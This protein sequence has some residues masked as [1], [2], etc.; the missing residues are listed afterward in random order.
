M[1]YSSSSCGSVFGNVRKIRLA[2]QI[3]N[4]KK[5]NKKITQIL[6]LPV[7]KQV[8]NITKRFQTQ[9][10][11]CR[12]LELH[13]IPGFVSINEKFPKLRKS[14]DP[15][16]VPNNLIRIVISLSGNWKKNIVTKT[17]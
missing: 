12:M 16:K 9:E 14:C 2:Q 3:C 11:L 6:Q 4:M 10:W 8:P 17:S 13:A 1:K 15:L 5:S 7:M